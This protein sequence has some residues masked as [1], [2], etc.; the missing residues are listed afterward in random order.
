MIKQFIY[1]FLALSSNDK[2]CSSIS[3]ERNIF[4][5]ESS[6]QLG[7]H[8][9]A[10]IFALFNQVLWINCLFDDFQLLKLKLISSNCYCEILAF[11]SREKSFNLCF[12]TKH[13]IV[14]IISLVSPETFARCSTTSI[15]FI[16]NQSRS[17]FLRYIA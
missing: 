7:F 8:V 2:C 11:F 16:N 12:F 4:V 10:C 17:F 15:S 9:F 6:I 3:D 1:E 13:N 5:L 14:S